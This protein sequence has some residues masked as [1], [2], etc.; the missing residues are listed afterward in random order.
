VSKTR[1]RRVDDREDEAMR[2]ASKSTVADD[3]EEEAMRIASKS[4]V[5]SL[6]KKNK[7]MSA[8]DEQ[9][10]DGGSSPASSSSS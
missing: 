4:T 10:N 2:I 8:V 3:K 9:D 1:E 5:A 6:R 7:D